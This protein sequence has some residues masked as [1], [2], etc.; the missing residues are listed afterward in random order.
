MALL[1]S[2]NYLTLRS[3]YSSLAV[4][5]PLQLQP[6]DLAAALKL[7]LDDTL[8]LGI[9]ASSFFQLFLPPLV[10]LTSGANLSGVCWSEIF[11]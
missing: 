11:L 4:S 7:S 3:P 9:V 2:A 8:L 6:V 1:T 10:G 5:S